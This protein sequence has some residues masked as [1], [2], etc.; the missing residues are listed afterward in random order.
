VRES[1]HFASVTAKWLERQDEW[2]RA[3]WRFFN[4]FA[5]GVFDIN[6]LKVS[7]N[8]FD[9]LP[10]SATPIDI[11][12][13]PDLILAR[14]ACREILNQLPQTAERDGALDCLGRIGKSSLRRKVGHRTKL[15]LDQAADQFP[16]LNRVVD[17]AVKCRN[18]YVHGTSGS[19]DYDRNFEAVLFF[20]R[21]LE[22]IFAASDLIESGWNF[23]RWLKRGTA[24][25][26][27]FGQY[28]VSYPAAIARLLQLL[29]K[30]D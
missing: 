30:R 6:R 4:S 29:P 21:S 16:E 8:M 25:T 26:H 5:Q 9:V 17:E 7:A 23:T 13:T 24:L 18:Y 22:F 14:Q 28:K 27:P 12:L 19:F 15:V 3:R 2:Q 11:A 10:P 1:E 20:T